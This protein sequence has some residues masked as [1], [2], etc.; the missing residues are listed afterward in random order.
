LAV[1]VGREGRECHGGEEMLNRVDKSREKKSV[2]R[3]VSERIPPR[4]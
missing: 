2:E 1:E 3:E 4:K